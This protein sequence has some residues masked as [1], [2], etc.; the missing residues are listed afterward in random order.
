MDQYTTIVDR[1]TVIAKLQRA[2][3]LEL[4]TIPPYLTAFFSIQ[5]GTNQDAASIIRSVFLE[6]MLHMILAGN[7]LSSIGGHLKLNQNNIPEYPLLLDFEG[8]AFKDREFLVNLARLSPRSLCTFLQIELPSDWDWEATQGKFCD[9]FKDDGEDDQEFDVHGYTI[10]DFY[11]GI[12]RDLEALVAQ[13]GGNESEV[14]IGNVDHQIGENFYWSGGGRPVIVTDLTSAF[15]AIDE[16]IEQGEGSPPVSVLDGDHKYFGQPEEVAHFFR[17]NEIL[18]ERYYQDD[19]DPLKPP[20][21]E[22]FEV[23]YKKVQPIKP[24][25]KSTDFIYTPALEELNNQF[26]YNYTL[27]LKQIEQG[28]NGTP[29][30]LYTAIRN[31]MQNLVPLAVQMTNIPIYLDPFNRTG[32]PSFEWKEH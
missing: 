19:D 9:K 22:K 17:F 27:M 28:F 4:S 11:D 23:D 30:I 13:H 16:I 7:V 20:T 25:C 18:M 2:V 8:K 10:G 21:G 29:H 15:K 6:E 14:F 3:E 32:A 12:K 31:G 26:N 1:E 24:N 5:P